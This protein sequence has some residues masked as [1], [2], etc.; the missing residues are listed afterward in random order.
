MRRLWSVAAVVFSC[1]VFAPWANASSPLLPPGSIDESQLVTLS[2]NT[3]PEALDPANDRGI[4]ADRR[5]LSHL[6]LVLKRPPA[7]EAAFERLVAQLTDRASPNYHSWLT[8]QQIGEQY[9]PLPEDV[10]AVKGWL[11][12]HGFSINTVF[13]S[14]LAI[15]F[16]GDAGK[17]REAFHTEIHTLD[18]HGWTHIANMSDPRIPAALAPLIGGVVSLSDFHGHAESQKLPP[19]TMKNCNMGARDLTST[20]YFVAPPDLAT[21]YDINPLFE[22]GTTGTGETIAVVEDSDIYTARDWKM[23]RSLFGLSGYTNGSLSQ[24]QPGGCTDPGTNSDDFEATLDMEYSSAAAPD[25]AIEVASCAASGTTWGVTIAVEN[26]VN[27]TSPPPIISNSYGECESG[28]GTANNLIYYDT[29]QQAA[30]EG[31]SV[32]VATGDSGAAACDDHPK[33]A[34]YGIAVD[35]VA[36]TPYD[37]AVGGT[38]FGDTYLH[39]NNRYWSQLNGQGYKSALSY[40]PEIPWNESCASQLVARYVTLSKLTYGSDGFCNLAQDTNFLTIWSGNGGPS[41]CALAGCTGYPKPSWQTVLGNPADNV[42]DLP[43]V[44]LFAAGEV[45]GHAYMTCYSD[46]AN[47]GESCKKFPHNYNFGYGTSFGAPIMAGIQALVD[48]STGSSQGNP[49]PTLYSLADAEYGTSGNPS[50]H[51]NLGKKIGTSCVFHDVTR[52]DMDVPCVAGSPNCYLPSGTYGVLSNSIS[53]Y[54]PAFRAGNG[55]DFATGLGSVDAANLV[56][57]WPK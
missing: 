15:D 35:G 20:C 22:N 37:V 7:R 24:V 53:Q 32:F 26:L 25:A 56:N 12:A 44:S 54:E 48:Q 11:V 4:V 41:S 50:C 39:E 3:R 17:V 10:A 47:G 5:P 14:R 19:L 18:V 45:W 31:M 55:W 51:S 9:G 52:G 6:F 40:I 43:D 30:A 23:F 33:E 46:P 49:N 57:S 42:R 36:S 28:M 13:P 27:Q 2:G 38:D 8:A 1:A 16:S 29:W 34:K 21:I